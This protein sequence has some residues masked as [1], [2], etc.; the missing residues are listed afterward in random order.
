MAAP[1][2][3]ELLAAQAEHEIADLRQVSSVLDA[4]APANA[5]GRAVR[6]R[7]AGLIAGAVAKLA[8]IKKDA[9][10]GAGWAKLETARV[11]ASEIK[12]EAL[13]FTQ[14]ELLRR[15]GHDQGI[16]EVAE[17][18]LEHLRRRT[19]VERGVLLS[20]AENEFFEHTVSMVRSR[21]PDVSVWKLP[22]LAHEFGHHVAS[23]LSHSDPAL[24]DD[25]RPVRA[26][27]SELAGTGPDRKVR[28]A[29]ANELFADVYATYVLGAAY[30][31]AMFTLAAR[32]DVPGTTS[33]TH[34]PWSL[35]VRTVEATVAV[36]GE[37]GQANCDGY[38]ALGR[39]L[40]TLADTVAANTPCTE[41]IRGRAKAMVGLLTTHALPGAR[42]EMPARVQELVHDRFMTSPAPDVTIADVLNAAWTWRLDHWDCED[43]LLGKV[44]KRALALCR[45]VKE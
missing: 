23:A 9:N 15:S 43:W 20:V 25:F 28:L 7:F 22:V 8:E 30:P 36:L 18:L 1:T 35:R 6:D 12:K 16:G 24:R 45:E 42:Y 10:P 17:H 40:A 26:H 2:S 44:S 32:P 31:F 33:E 14:G 38:S 13:S 29:H 27:L 37:D 34:P 39:V 4:V 19:G 11:S 5:T 3:A 21:F 41:E